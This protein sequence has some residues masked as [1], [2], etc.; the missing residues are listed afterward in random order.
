MHDYVIVGAGPAGGVLAHRLSEDPGVRVL[1]LEAGGESQGGT[2]ASAGDWG[3][4]TA[5]Q[6][7]LFERR[8][9]WPR[10]KMLGGSSALNTMIAL[11]G[12]RADYDGWAADGCDGWS[13]AEVLPYF[14][15]LE[16]NARGASRYHGDRGPL[17][18]ADTTAPHRLIQAFVRAAIEAG[19][20]YNADFNSGTQEGV[21]LNQVTQRDG[22]PHNAAD[23]YLQPVRARENLT[24]MTG[25][26]VRRVEIE[27]GR[28]TGV[29]YVE[30]GIEWSAEASAE[31]ILCAGAVGS[32]QLLMLSGLG[33]ADHLEARGLGVTRDLPS[34]GENLQDHLAVPVCQGVAGAV[35]PEQ[36]SPWGHA[37]PPLLAGS[38]PLTSKGA[39]A[40]A[41]IRSRPGLPAPDLQLHAAS[42]RHHALSESED[43]AFTLGATLL[44]P[45]SRGRLT[46]RPD[47]PTG[48]PILQPRYCSDPGGEDL[49][50]LVAGLRTARDIFAQRPFARFRTE[51]LFHGS[52]KTTDAE[53]RA[54]VRLEAETTYDPVGTCAMGTGIEAVVDPQLRVRGVE[55]LR[56]ADASVMPRIVRGNTPLPTI[57]IG[58]K[59][60]DLVRSRAP[61]PPEET[62]AHTPARAA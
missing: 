18:V 41:F 1:L 52:E 19:L 21:G 28:A 55:G 2:E 54:H 31:V 32:P 56:V 53:L 47:D 24:V 20:P 11:R 40:S 49:A 7:H 59:A 23:A 37:A 45:Q 17:H 38:G 57:M 13:Y 33:P 51:E 14:K 62:P 50:A 39:E 44:Q 60:A 46:L 8:L 29:T 4:T 34:V 35:S 3:Y 43:D 61:L 42:F 36:G 10:G 48:K 25:A 15:R 9:H 30:D 12:H 5:P 16:T 22:R 26:H 27:D 6:E 58:E